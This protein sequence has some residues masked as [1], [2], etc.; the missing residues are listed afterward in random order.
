MVHKLMERLKNSKA[1]H[2][3]MALALV[4]SSLPVQAFA[5]ETQTLAVQ[6]RES[7]TCYVVGIDRNPSGASVFQLQMPDGQVITGY[8]AN[9]GWPMPAD[10]SYA[11]DA[12][13]VGGGVYSVTVHSSFV[14]SN[15]NDINPMEWSHLKGAPPWRT[16][17]ITATWV[18]VQYGQISLSKVSGNP[19]LTDGNALY[20]LAGAQYGIFTDAGCT[21]QVGTLTTDASG[22]ATSGNLE[23]GPTYYVKEIAAPDGYTLDPTV[24]PVNISANTVTPVNGGTPLTDTPIND[25]AGVLVGKF[26]GEKTYNGAANLPQGAASLAGAEFTVKYYDGF[27]DTAEQAE[28]SG[29]PTRTWVLATN[30]NGYARL[31]TDHLVSG[32]ALYTINGIPTVPRGTLV[33]QETK[34][35]EGYKLNSEVFVQQVKKPGDTTTVSTYNEPQVPDEVYRGG[36]SVQKLDS[37]T[38]TN[39]QGNA[40]LEGITFSIINDNGYA[41]I[42]DGVSYEPDAVVKTLVTDD[43]GFATTSADALPFGDYII[44]ETATNDTYLNTAGD[45]HA[46][47]SE[48]GKVYAFTAKDDV[49]RGGVKVSKRDIESVLSTPLG[50]ASID[51]TQFQ[52]KFQGKNPIVVDGITFTEGQVI[53]TLVIKDGEASTP[54]AYLPVGDYSLQE[55]VAGD[56]YLLTDGSVYEFS[57]TKQGQI[58][59]AVGTPV[60]NQVK[61]GDL[62]FVKVREDD[63]ARLA[64]VPF[65]IT[66]ETT[67]E[68]HI[69]VTDENGYAST[70]AEWNKHTYKTNEN[71]AAE[72]GAYSDEAGIWFGLGTDGKTV[73]A[74]DSLGAL[75]YD[76]YT[77]EELSC[78]ANEG[79]ELV[80]IE[81]VTIKRDSVTIDLGTIDDGPSPAAYIHTTASDAADG[82][83]LVLA[84]DQ[85]VINDHVEFTGLKAGE[86]Y[87]MTATL[88]DK[89]TGEAIGA[90]VSKDF[91]PANASG[92]VEMQIPVDLLDYA[93]KSVVVFEELTRNGQPIADHKDLEDTEQTLRV[94]VPSIGTTA[95][96]GV[97]GDQSIVI[98]PEA[99]VIDT[100][101]YKNLMP[102]R[103][104]TVTG[105]L[106]VK[107]TEEPLLD[108]EGNPVTSQATFTPEDPTG[109]VD[110][111]FTFDATDLA[112]EQV[113]AFETL[114]RGDKEL[115]VHA[116]IEDEG[117]TVEFT[118]PEIG[119]TAKDGI[120]GDQHSAIDPESVIVDTVSYT[121]LVPGKEYTVKGTL[122]V[123]GEDEDGEATGEPLEDAD[124]N[125]VTAEAAFTPDTPSGTV[126]VTFTFDSTKLAGE[127]VVVFETLYRNGI[128]ITAHADIEDEGQTVDFTKPEIGTTAKDSVD[129]DH[130]AV[131]DPETSIVDTVS[132]TGLIPGKEYTVKGV[133]MN[134]ATEEPLEIDGKKVEAEATFTPNHPSGTVDVTFNF[135]ASA[136]AGEQ[137]VAFETLYRNGIEITAHADIED[138]GQTVEFTQPEIGTTAKDGIDADKFIV[139]DGSATLIDTISYTGLIPGREY[140][141]T[142]TLMSKET[143]EALLDADGNPVTAEAAFTPDHDHGTVDVTFTFDCLQLAGQQVVAFETVS[144]LNEEIAV[145]ADIED[146][147]QTVTIIQ[148]DVD[149]VALDGIDGDREAVI[150]PEAVISD[151]VFFNN[152]IPGAAYD[153][154]GI[155]MDRDTGLPMLSDAEGEEISEDEL[156]GFWQQLVDL[157]GIKTAAPLSDEAAAT[158]EPAQQDEGGMNLLD[159][160]GAFLT[161]SD[162]SEDAEADDGMLT[163]VW[164]QPVQPDF[165]G[166][167]AL[168]AENPEIASRLVYA[169]SEF[170]PEEHYGE[171]SMDFNID[172]TELAGKSAVVFELLCK[173]GWAVAAHAD[174]TDDDQ[175][176][177]FVEPEIGTTAKD[178]FDGGSDAVIDPEASIVDTVS[179]DGLIPGKE[180]TVKGTLMV[181][182]TGEALLD[183]DG[184]P[185]TSEA[186]FTPDHDHGTV[187][188]TFNFD[189]SALA[190]EQVVVFETLYRNGKE[191]TA[192][193]DIE[194]EGQTV[195]YTQPEIGTTAADAV[196]GDQNIVA[197][198]AATIVDTVSYEGLLPGREYKVTGT[199]MSKETGEALLDADGNPVTA[200]AL[201]TPDHDHGTVDVTFTFDAT[202]LAGQ[203]VVAFE[204]VSR[205]DK[206]IAV[207]ADIEDEA[208]TV[209]AV[210]PGVD[211]VAVDGFDD[212]K[213][214][215]ADPEASI[216][217]TVS[218]E[219]VIPGATYDLYGIVMDADTG[220][221][222][223]SGEGADAISEEALADFWQQLTELSGV[224]TATPLDEGDAGSAEGEGGFD[225]F[226]AVAEFFT[227]GSA[228]EDAEAED[229]ASTEVWFPPVT[230]DWE[231]ID[232]LLAENE[233]IVSHLSMAQATFEAEKASGEI[234]MDFGLDASDLAGKK[235]VVFELLCKDGMAVGA[236]SD[237][238]DEDQT[239]NIV[240][241]T[242]GTEATDKTD[243][244]HEVMVSQKATVVDTVTYHD[245]LPGKEYTVEGVLMDKS[246][247]KPLMVDDQQVT[248][249]ARFT[250]NQPDGT[251][252]LEFTFDA[253]ALEGK[254]VVAF[255]TLYK[256]GIEVAAHTDINDE[257][258]TVRFVAPPEGTT[259]DK[260]GNP[261]SGYGWVAVL[262][263]A[264]AVAG[265]GY[266]GKQYLSSR[267]EQGEGTGDGDNA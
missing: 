163:G 41:V 101:S 238:T 89:E 130:Y 174:I 38:G 9:H 15:R 138:E 30:E 141:A 231:G 52:L 132:Y 214:V 96:D 51:G 20:T 175:T 39:P 110:V 117:Q 68:S 88:M 59:D 83:K 131:I 188:V 95:K 228:D 199:L 36:V 44:R 235:A 184:N 93:G 222:L 258:Q 190:G 125:P 17:G 230:P 167:E 193:A 127:S 126:D 191:I 45:I 57:V 239:V 245:L 144:R 178:G 137:V 135:D 145:H 34:A 84:D 118:Q 103:E 140:K 5:A 80:R 49:V 246:T 266:A 255:E 179:Y 120:D 106:M 116:D 21:A 94:L 48:D 50:G 40:S 259:Y 46:T 203:Q 254:E 210:Q 195:E 256:D 171:I 142:G 42:V 187:D 19:G 172:A 90:S 241:S 33:I 251:V 99:T 169:T 232:A 236:H 253:S 160:I 150:D 73:A 12:V 153:V 250:P 47:V 155:V 177:P 3:L 112:G 6:S 148:P 8:C 105:T 11:F 165:E 158:E 168:F 194:D 129:G 207:H 58:V 249:E 82:D 147:G 218:Y 100:V 202:M 111:A 56:G 10:G 267:K 63:M 240:A 221:P 69:I 211:T 25:P 233:D 78:E 113:V 4:V 264:A 107:G 37:Q 186:T 32:D 224:I 64:G 164:F 200:E 122:M 223:L 151:T 183:A 79:L 22:N 124:G 212:D 97:D 154:Y 86:S 29:A 182:G 157:A 35:P 62:E 16:Q 136:L 170:T 87:T 217:D 27:Y 134:K 206:E 121:G 65:R 70:S 226:G 26:D 213:D 76:T 189:A 185:V 104:Y 149:T 7:G 261:F 204:T 43:K 23:V 72:E 262:L 257:A 53:E 55:V 220:L 14:T 216:T 146:G 2:L 176:I 98:D 67:G 265:A 173:D 66:S 123:K 252:E 227:G 24:Y 229:A 166:I 108:A 92:S 181:K 54:A 198:P 139:A 192:H 260:T 152:V 197:D 161:G 77:I 234:S 114:H 162:A 243:G 247:G 102:G 180:Y 31:S 248:A 225:F 208:Q 75:P 28:A 60:L 156:A 244:D 61:R 74:N 242:I 1:F 201:F 237:L 115:A 205:L 91:T 159:W 109:T 196:D 263:A 128:E 81:G 133:L 143:G 13:D 215:V 219:N 209:T 18:R 85:A 71:D 119:T